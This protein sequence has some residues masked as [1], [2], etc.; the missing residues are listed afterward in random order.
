MSIAS[1]AVFAGFA[2]FAMVFGSGNIVFPPI[3]GKDFT[4]NFVYALLGWL[5]TTVVIP[6]SGYFGAMLFDG[7][8]KKYLSPLGKHATFIFMLVLMMMVGPFGVVA[9]GVN[10]SFGGIHLLAPNISEIG[11]N[12][13]Y[14]ILTILLAWNPGKIVQ[15]M[16][17]V[18]TPLKFGGVIIVTLGALYFGGS[19]SEIPQSNESAYTAFSGGFKEGFQTMDLLASFLMATSIFIYL[20]NSLPEDKKHDKKMM[21]RFSG[22]ACLVGGLVLTIVYTGLVLIG[23]QYATVLQGVPNESLFPKIAE[24][25]MG[26]YASWFV[27]VV[28]AACCLATN[29]VLS[30]VF[31]DFVHKDILK[32]KFNRKIILMLVG[33]LTFAMSLL[34]FY[35]IC[36]ILANVLSA[37]YPAL[38]IFTIA[39]IAYY[40]SKIH[41]KA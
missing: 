40:F 18:F 39:R 22:L 16:G 5:A 11:F 17:S 30:S 9:R 32:E 27:A 34:G 24:L 8:S 26:S 35:E 2:I 33:A 36:K 41:K 25:A 4:S 6:I 23:A 37:I 29:I 12:V 14:C 15:I 21:L 1:K 7:D 3:I 19:L 10:V 28:V 13:L 38:I 31:T 20:K